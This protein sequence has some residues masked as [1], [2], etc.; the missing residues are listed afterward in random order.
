MTC[1]FTLEHHSRVN[2]REVCH[3]GTEGKLKDPEQSRRHEIAT[4]ADTPEPRYAAGLGTGPGRRRCTT[5]ISEVSTAGGPDAYSATELSL[6]ILSLSLLPAQITLVL[7]FEGAVRQTDPPFRLSRHRPGV[8][9]MTSA[10]TRKRIPAVVDSGTAG[11]AVG[12]GRTLAHD[13][14][15][16][17]ESP[18]PVPRVDR[19]YSV[20]MARVPNL[21]AIDA[22]RCSRASGT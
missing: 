19:I 11:R 9:P 16:H 12:L 3:S 13:L 10:L 14:A 15:R 2:R 8:L 4:R 17:S 5:C 22:P 18:V 1:E 6:P 7:Q 20:A 21:L